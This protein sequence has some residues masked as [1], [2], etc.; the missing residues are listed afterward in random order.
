MDIRKKLM[1][2]REGLE[3]NGPINIVIFGDSV[4]HGAV[5][6]DETNYET[7]YYNRLKQKINAVRNY[8]PVNM[9]NAAIGGTDAT[10]SVER[11]DSHVLCYKPD[12]VIV[13]FGLNDVNGTLE[14]Y[15]NS[16]ETIFSRL[17][18]SGVE[19]IFMTPNM[20]NTYVADETEDY[21]VE[22]ATITAEYQNSGK[23]DSF[24]NSAVELANRMGIAVCD[25]YSKWKKLSKTEDTTKLLANH[26]NHPIKEMHE[27]FAQSLFELLFGEENKD[28]VANDSTMYR[29]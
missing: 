27:L 18:Q 13:C 23:M 20:L 15:I 7:V 24:M 29:K 22:Y 4:S 8:I 26:I 9:I 5:A 10:A 25:C 11:I 1:M 16:L 3:K 17:T 2:D 21:L 19:V 6:G 14:S 28:A 12:M